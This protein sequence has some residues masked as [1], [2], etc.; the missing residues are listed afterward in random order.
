MYSEQSLHEPLQIMKEFT[1]FE[2]GKKRKFRSRKLQ[3]DRKA[4]VLNIQQI[5]GRV[6]K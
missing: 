5:P 6:T 4:K 1:P 2:S 3:N